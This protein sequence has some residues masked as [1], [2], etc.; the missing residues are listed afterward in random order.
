[1]S[2]YTR[3][4]LEKAVAIGAVLSSAN[5]FGA[6]LRGA[7]LRGADLRGADLR[8][9]SLRGADLF[10]ADLSGASLSG[11]DPSSTDLSGAIGLPTAPVVPDLHARMAEECAV[12]DALDMN[13]WHTCKTT[14][15]RAGWAIALAGEA[16][17]ALEAALGPSVAGALIYH[18]STGMVP[19][20]YASNE[21]AMADIIERAK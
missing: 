21:D 8:S 12:V 7:K 10:G 13:T 11:A 5:L 14:H 18:A 19:D 16:G 3:S 20:F 1:M 6:N 17:A 15:C 9:A 2:Q 4:E